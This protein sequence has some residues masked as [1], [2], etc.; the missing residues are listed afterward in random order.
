[1]EK[2]RRECTVSS[3]GPQSVELGWWRAYR[4]HIPTWVGTI[5]LSSFQ[6][7]THSPSSQDHW[8]FLSYTT[9]YLCSFSPLPPFPKQPFCCTLAN[10]RREQAGPVQC[11]PHLPCLLLPQLFV[12]VDGGKLPNGSLKEAWKWG[13]L[14]LL[15]LPCYSPSLAPGSWLAPIQEVTTTQD[16]TKGQ[17]PFSLLYL[18]GVTNIF[19]LEKIYNCYL[20]TLCQWSSGCTYFKD[21]C[22]KQ[23]FS[24]V[25]MDLCES[26]VFMVYSACFF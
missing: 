23:W 4:E 2:L 3:P 17:L 10:D 26:K 18:A 7:G 19:F 24:V 16:R 25:R 12:E 5:F 15:L 6:W 22:S 21:S 11:W 1:M 20:I 13:Y 9:I 14:F 8:S